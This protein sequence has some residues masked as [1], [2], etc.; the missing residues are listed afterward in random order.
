M[1]QEASYLSPFHPRGLIAI[2]LITLTTTRNIS[3]QGV[4]Q[5]SAPPPSAK[6]IKC[7]DRSIPQLV[8]VTE[9]AGIR[10]SHSSS[11]ANRYIAESMNGGVLLLDYDRDG[12]VD[13]YFTNAPTVEMANKG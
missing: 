8:D 2:L 10:F 9:K 6:A 12:W 4:A 3:A 5:G 13:I 1:S 7:K 11:P